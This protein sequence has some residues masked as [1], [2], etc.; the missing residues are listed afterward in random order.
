MLFAVGPV[1][2][3]HGALCGDD[4]GLFGPGGGW[5]GPAAVIRGSSRGGLLREVLGE[6][7]RCVVRPLRGSRGVHWVRTDAEASGAA[8]TSPGRHV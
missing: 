6:A 3:E 5:E 8:G 7:E 1:V 4:R 2:C